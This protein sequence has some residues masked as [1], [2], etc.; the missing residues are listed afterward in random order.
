MSSTNN[1][2]GG[3]QIGW[4]SADITPEQPVLIA[5]QFHARV[6][7]GVADPI[8]AT[9]LALQSGPE[10]AILVSCDLVGISDELRDTVRRVVTEALP[11]VEPLKVVLNAT[12]THTGPEVREPTLGAG[13]VSMGTGVDLDVQPPADYILWAGARIGTAAVAAWRNRAPGKVA[14]GLGQAAIGHN[15]RWVDGEGNT[16]MYGDTA[17]PGF[18]HIEGSEDHSVGLLASSDSSG[19][20]TGLAINVPC[21]SQVSEGDY[22]LSA[23]YW[24]ETRR[25]LRRRLGVDLHILAQCSVAGDQSPH[26]IMCKAAELR[27]LELKGRSERQEIACRIA[28]AV[29]ATLPHITGT[30]DGDPLFRHVVET[31]ELP[32]SRLDAG[33]VT[34]ADSEAEK[35]RDAYEE[36]LD[37]LRADPSLRDGPRWYVPVTRAYRRMNWYRGVAD[38][39][40]RSQAGEARPA[41]VHVLRLGDLAIATNPFEYYLDFGLHIKARSP[42][43]QIL[44]VQ[45][46]GGGT[47]VPSARSLAGGGY[48]S[49][50]ASNPVGPEGGRLLAE[51]TVAVLEEIFGI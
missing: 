42:A 11:D 7:E 1:S 13:H 16:T 44:L 40:G 48:G 14:F 43:V 46:A 45:L 18:R 6:S 22:K 10:H 38:R 34:A 23:D 49:V 27:M 51:R 47:Y 20:L 12:H 30:A 15:R 21:P 50:P 4:G 28:D 32:M 5:G 2:T 39:F 31:V 41:E 35:L 19:A 3:L 24:C 36:E 33:A 29:D 17:T 37:K 9:A 26:P 8:T 25:E